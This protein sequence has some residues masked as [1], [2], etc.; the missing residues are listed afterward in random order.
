MKVW[1]VV[2][3]KPRQEM[4][5]EAN[6][7]RQGFE[8]YLPRLAVRRRRRGAWVEVVEALFPRYLFVH[9]EVGCQSTAPIRSTRGA[10]GL[11]RFGSESA[12]V[13][14]GVIAAIRARED[15]LSGL[16]ANP[17]RLFQ[18]GQVVSVV[19]GPLAGLQGVFSCEDG[20]QRAM[21]LI[22]LLGK[23]HRV[24]VANNWIARAA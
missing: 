12:E 14:D 13:S 1:H 5:A 21:L 17:D 16:H 23:T 9:I 19:D 11:V 8:V 15:G 10:F 18:P 22:D 7:V 4:V 3:C 20:E 24:A 2:V 6:L